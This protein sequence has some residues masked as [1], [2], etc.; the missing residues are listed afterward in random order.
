MHC[1]FVCEISLCV[2]LWPC[3]EVPG[4][5][6]R[7][8]ATEIT[9]LTWITVSSCFSEALILTWTSLQQFFKHLYTVK[10]NLLL[11]PRCLVSWGLKESGCHLFLPHEKVKAARS[12]L[13]SRLDQGAALNTAFSS[14][15]SGR[16][17]T[18]S[19]STE[20]WG[21]GKAGVCPSALG[22]GHQSP[23]EE[24]EWGLLWAGGTEGFGGQICAAG[25]SRGAHGLCTA[26]WWM[27]CGSAVRLGSFVVSFCLNTLWLFSTGNSSLQLISMVKA[28]S[29]PAAEYC[30]WCVL[31]CLERC[32]FPRC[33]CPNRR[34][35]LT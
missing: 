20:C 7:V 4:G 19:G 8:L 17:F 10:I 18:C 34:W 28:I 11:S 2:V 30:F 25:K 32:W 33:L 9:R 16:P 35:S 21:C 27:L 29:H 14:P 22:F 31:C 13:E 5:P 23:C 26:C 1:P 24:A 6:G 12:P 3:W 15:S